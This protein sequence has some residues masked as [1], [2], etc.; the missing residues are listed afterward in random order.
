[1]NKTLL[2]ALFS[3]LLTS[4]SRDPLKK[5][6]TAGAMRNVMW[7]GHLQGV[8]DLDT[9]ANKEH[10][11]GLGP[12]EYLS[13]EIVIVDGTAYRSTVLTDSTMKV[14]R[15]SAVKA[16]FFVYAQLEQWQEHTLPDSIHSI[17]Q[18]EKFLNTVTKTSPRPFAFKLA[19]IVESATIHIVNL[20]PGTAVSSP[21]EAHHGQVNYK[22]TNQ[23]AELIGFFSTAHKGVFTH[24]DSF[25][26][27]HLITADKAKMGHL[28]RLN[29]KP[30][31][32]KLYLPSLLML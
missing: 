13:G 4:C 6:Y 8:I 17:P 29:I 5:V 7:K 16:P 31:S 9:I 25:V 18:L 30:G 22:L 20:P 27:I 1:M 12:V 32:M 23:S 26:H 2:L 15:T 19:G 21:T 11:Y 14:E 28:D 3:L 10:L 24:H